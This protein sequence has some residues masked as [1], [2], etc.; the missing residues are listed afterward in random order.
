MRNKNMHVK[1]ISKLGKIVGMPA[2]QANWPFEISEKCSFCPSLDLYAVLR[3][4][5]SIKSY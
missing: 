5:L 4:M 2:H 3:F 1:H